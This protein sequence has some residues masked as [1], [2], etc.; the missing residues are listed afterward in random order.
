MKNLLTWNNLKKPEDLRAGQKI[1]V[2]K[3]K[4]VP[5]TTQKTVAHSNGANTIRVRKGQTLSDIAQQFQVS[6]STLMAWNGLVRATDLQANQVLIVSEPKKKVAVSSSVIAP[7]V[8]NSSHP[9]KIVVRSGD[10][11]SEI[12]ERFNTSVKNLMAWNGLVRAADLQANQ[13][14]IVNLN[15]SRSHRV[16]IGD[17]LWHIAKT[18]RTSVKKLIAVNELQSNYL[19]PNQTLIIPD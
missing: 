1:I 13:A 5:V 17:T 16:R 10:T 4:S 12:A 18:Y 6:V 19:Q 7:T 9:V 14:L 11:L 15:Q 2:R 3:R 8:P